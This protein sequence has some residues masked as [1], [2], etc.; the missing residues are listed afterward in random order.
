[1]HSI[2]RRIATFALA[3]FLIAATSQAAFAS[4]PRGFNSE[5]IYPTTRAVNDMHGTHPA[6]KLTLFPV[7]L[8]LDTVFLPFG[9]L[10]G[11]I[12]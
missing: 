9:V 6:L 2:R 7:T 10:A 3:T 4:G 8:A 1:M 11:F 12:A 5:Y